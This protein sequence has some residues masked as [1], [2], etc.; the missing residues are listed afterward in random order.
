MP[1]AKH[2]QVPSLVIGLHRY[3]SNLSCPAKIRNHTLVGGQGLERDAC[4]QLPNPI[5]GVSCKLSTKRTHPVAHAN[6]ARAA[7]W[8]VTGLLP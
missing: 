5:F 4:P 8:K 1:L 7:T 3:M 2:H 6:Q